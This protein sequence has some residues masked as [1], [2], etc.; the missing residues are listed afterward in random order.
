MGARRDMRSLSSENASRSR[1]LWQEAIDDLRGVHPLHRHIGARAAAD[2][3]PGDGHSLRLVKGADSRDE[4]T[5]G[6][7]QSLSA[8][9]AFSRVLK[10]I[11]RRTHDHSERVTHYALRLAHC[12]GVTG[13]ELKQLHYG[14]LLHD[15]GKIGVSEAILNKPGALTEDEFDE[16]KKHPLHGVALLDAVPFLREAIPTVR[17]HHERFDG[18]GYPDGLC[19][20]QIPLAARIVCVADAFDAMTNDRPYR[21]R[22]DAS[23]AR[24]ILCANRGTQFDPELVEAFVDGLGIAAGDDTSNFFPT[25]AAA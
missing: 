4:M 24:G 15:C 1:S 3:H 5:S 20:E 18:R 7:R 6:L 10:G 14:A 23:Q 11:D 19:G 17:H 2:R 8:L 21:R 9:V 13:D 12:V 25:I 22:F 16:V